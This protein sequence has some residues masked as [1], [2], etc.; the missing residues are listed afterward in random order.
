[1]RAK[2]FLQWGEIFAKH[3][4]DVDLSRKLCR[5]HA[6]ASP[7][8][9]VFLKKDGRHGFL[10]CIVVPLLQQYKLRTGDSHL[11]SKMWDELGLRNRN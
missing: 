5:P 8:H 10:N 1:M 4:P 11:A 3:R 2:L 6:I 7:A 9:P